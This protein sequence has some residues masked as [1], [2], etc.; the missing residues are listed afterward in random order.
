MKRVDTDGDWSTFCPDECPGLQD[1]WGDDYE[2]LYH[3]YESMGKARDTFK[4]RKLWFAILDSQ[5]ETGTPY[6]CYKDAVN[7]KSN[8]Q[9]L[10]TI[11]SSNLCCEITG[12]S[13]EETAV[14]TLASISL[15]ACV[16]DGTFDFDHLEHVVKIATRNLDR[17]I[18]VNDYP[19]AEAKVSNERHRPLGLQSP[20]TFRC[21]SDVV[22]PLR[23]G[24]CCSVEQGYFRDDL[25]FLCV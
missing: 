25:L 15:P 5:M 12:T 4:A 11:R 6:L 10:G 13:P 23:F 14:C 7:S 22:S 3:E 21:L 8:Q 16:K 17:V 1:A 9:N 18:D 19:V 2:R 24:R 20:E